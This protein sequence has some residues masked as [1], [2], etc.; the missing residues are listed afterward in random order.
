MSLHD[1]REPILPLGTDAPVVLGVSS[2][3]A[4][5][6]SSGSMSEAEAQGDLPLQP[7]VATTVGQGGAST[8][9]N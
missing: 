4:S 8:A 7:Q 5:D 9:I 2:S 3:S 6:S 1:L